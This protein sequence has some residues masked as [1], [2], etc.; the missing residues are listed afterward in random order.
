VLRLFSSLFFG[1]GMA[2]GSGTIWMYYATSVIY[3]FIL[4][5]VGVSLGRRAVRRVR[6]DIF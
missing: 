5:G 1:F 3:S 4:G 6:R 2:L